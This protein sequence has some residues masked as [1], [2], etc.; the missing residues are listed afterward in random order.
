MMLFSQY[1]AD[2][3]SEDLDQAIHAGYSIDFNVGNKGLGIKMYGFSSK[4]K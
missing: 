1:L 2:Y 3:F 4:I